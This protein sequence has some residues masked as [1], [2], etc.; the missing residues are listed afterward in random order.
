MK[1]FLV[2]CWLA[3]L[4]SRLFL[5]VHTWLF[6]YPSTR[7]IRTVIEAQAKAMRT[8]YGAPYN[9][10]NGHP[11]HCLNCAACAIFWDS[12]RGHQF[13]EEWRNGRSVGR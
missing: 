6:P 13:Y 4:T 10:E 2:G 7:R 5:W 1:D 11:W 12:T 8:A 9:P 3:L